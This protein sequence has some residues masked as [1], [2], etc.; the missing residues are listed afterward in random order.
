MAVNTPYDDGVYGPNGPN[1]AAPARDRM[2]W[3]PM[4][5]I[6]TAP[7]GAWRLPLQLTTLSKD[8]G[9]TSGYVMARI[10]A[11]TAIASY[12]TIELR[13]ATGF[14]QGLTN[15]YLAPDSNGVVIHQVNETDVANWLFA[16]YFGNGITGRPFSWFYKPGDQLVNRFTGINITVISLDI[17]AGI[18]TIEISATGPSGGHVYS[19]PNACK[20]G[21]VWREG[22]QMDYA[23]VSPARR[24]QV[25]NDNGLGASRKVSGSQNCQPGFVWREAW[26]GDYVCVTSAERTTA[27]LESRQ[28]YLNVASD[29]TSKGIASGPYEPVVP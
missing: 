7:S 8:I 20:A 26:P 2:G 1:L 16:P 23:C 27:Q 17:L 9:T 4:N 21:L 22:D 18:A 14:D 3:L 10:P 19:G 29:W 6:Y 5:R 13:T 11:N 24:S 15:P 12:Y 25:K 28:A